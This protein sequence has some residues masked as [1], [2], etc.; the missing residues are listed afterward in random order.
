M[1]YEHDV[2]HPNSKIKLLMRGSL[3][4]DPFPPRESLRDNEWQELISIPT[5]A[6][7]ISAQI[8]RMGGTKRLN[9]S[10]TIRLRMANPKSTT[11]L[12]W[13]LVVYISFEHAHIWGLTQNNPYGITFLQN[14]SI[15]R[16]PWIRKIETLTIG[17]PEPLHFQGVERDEEGLSHHGLCLDVYNTDLNVEKIYANVIYS[18]YLERDPEGTGA[19]GGELDFP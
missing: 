18:G 6:S 14:K 13:E 19:G 4:S 1:A 10:T 17:F 2:Q 7:F 15:F 16:G 12:E 9:T 3:G 11:D 8:S 5:N